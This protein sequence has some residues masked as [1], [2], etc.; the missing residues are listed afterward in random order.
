MN[1]VVLVRYGDIVVLFIVIVL[2]EVKNVDFFLFIVNYEECL[3]VVG[4]IFGGFIKC[5]GCLSEKVILVSCLIDCLICL[6]FVD[7]FCNEV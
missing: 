5:E 6:L 1:G 4:K 3:Y 7:G 2:K